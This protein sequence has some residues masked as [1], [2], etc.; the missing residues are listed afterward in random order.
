MTILNINTEKPVS[1][2]SIIVI[3]F[4]VLLSIA[5]FSFFTFHWLRKQIN[6]G[7]QLTNKERI[8]RYY[9]HGWNEN[10]RVC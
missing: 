5:I 7:M 1:N 10:K 9:L 2:L 3:V 4:V 8:N 6:C